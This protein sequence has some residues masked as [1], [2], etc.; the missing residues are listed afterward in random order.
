MK[1]RVVVTGMGAVTP[2]G[3]SVGEMWENIKNGKNGIDYITLFDTAEHK[4]KV[5]AEVKDF[6]PTE[7]IEKKELR[8]LDRF[9]HFGI[10]AAVQAY[11]QSGL[12]NSG[13]A[14]EDIAVITGS[15]I[16]GM[17]TWESE[18]IK[19]MERGPSKVSPFMIPMIIPNILAGNISIKF[20]VKG[21]SHCVVTAC[22]SGTDAI[23]EAYNLICASKAKAVITGGAEAVITPF[24]LAGFS[25]MM[26]LSTRNDPNNS[27]T[28]F[29]RDRDGFVMGEG[30]G[31]LI[32]EDYESAKARGAVIYGEIVGYGA[33]CDAY[34]ITSPAPDGSGAAQAML[35]AIKD[36]GIAPS[37]VS[38]INAHGTSTPP[39]DKFE[40]IAIKDVFG[41]DAY[42]IPVSSTKS[43]TGHMLGAAGAVESIICIKA[44]EEGFIPPTINLKNPDEGL[45]LDYVPEKGR[46]QELKYAISNS[47]G[48]GGHNATLAFKRFE[49]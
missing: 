3:N 19:L 15:G 24:A 45:D 25:N 36:A 2:V 41:S 10:A 12:E 31:M 14:K 48:F 35:Q 27:S 13:I 6:D 5:A 20:G 47:L 37:D 42:N 38:Y 43:M 33:T 22:A 26:A 9:C 7:Y 11:N 28:P 40:T 29:D 34:H 16:G 39:N 21:L 8:R 1:K 30:A 32:L 18:H 49:D 46:R 17:N 44:L 4:A 23:G